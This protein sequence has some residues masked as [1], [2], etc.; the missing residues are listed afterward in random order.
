MLKHIDPLR[1]AEEIQESQ[2]GERADF[3]IF[4]SNSSDGFQ[5]LEAFGDDLS[6]EDDPLLD[7]DDL[8][9]TA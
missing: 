6:L 1:L 3:G 2:V 8:L 4:S 5:C 9:I 7:T